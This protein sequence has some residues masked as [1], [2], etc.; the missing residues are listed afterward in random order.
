M[1]ENMEKSQAHNSEATWSRIAKHYQKEWIEGM[2]KISIILPTYNQG[3]ILEET[4]QSILSQR[5]VDVEIILVDAGSSDSTLSV[6][7]IYREKIARI[8]FVTTHIL[9]LMINKGASL[10]T[11]QYIGVLF[12]GYLFLNVYSLCQIARIGSENRLPD[13]IYSADYHIDETFKRYREA[14]SEEL[15]EFE[16]MFT[17]YPFTKAYLKRGYLPTS[18]FCIWFKLQTFNEMGELNYHYS[19]SKSIFDFLCRLYRKEAIKTATTYWAICSTNWSEKDYLTISALFGR[20][21]LVIKYFGL[22]EGILWF[23]RDKPI[24]IISWLLQSLREVFTRE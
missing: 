21:L 19:F 20:L 2:P 12:P 9:P 4:I 6:I 10:A 1:S 22:H 5:N 23:F 8:Y 13:L 3:H 18:P 7:E 17:I 11:G 14:I 24:Y 16:P 15:S